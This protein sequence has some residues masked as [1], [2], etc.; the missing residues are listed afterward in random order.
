MWTKREGTSGG[1]I[2]RSENMIRESTDREK[3]TRNISVRMWTIKM[4]A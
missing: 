4:Q 1:Y 2:Q 3:E